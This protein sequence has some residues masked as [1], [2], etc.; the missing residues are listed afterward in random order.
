M[1]LLKSKKG[2]AALYVMVMLVIMT[3][4]TLAYA[5]LS[6]D[7][8]TS[9]TRREQNVTARLAFD[10]ATLKS[11]YDAGLNRVAVTSVNSR[12]RRALYLLQW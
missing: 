6:K 10:G 12:N 2:S 7:A 8:Y 9:E 3:T 11:C 1:A 4:I 5:D